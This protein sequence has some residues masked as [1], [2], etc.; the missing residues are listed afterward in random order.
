MLTREDLKWNFMLAC[1]YSGRTIQSLEGSTMDLI[2]IMLILSVATVSI[3]SGIFFMLGDDLD[4]TRKLYNEFLNL[5]GE[6]H[7]HSL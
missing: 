7:F 5:R 6:F 4:L 1:W 3:A 2:P